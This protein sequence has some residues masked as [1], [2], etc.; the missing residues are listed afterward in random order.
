MLNRAESTNS[1]VRDDIAVV[2]VSRVEAY[3]HVREKQEVDHVAEDR[4][5]VVRANTDAIHRSVETDKTAL[6]SQLNPRLAVGAQVV[7]FR[8]QARGRKKMLGGGNGGNF[9]CSFFWGAISWFVVLFLCLVGL[10]R[11]VK[12]KGFISCLSDCLPSTHDLFG[13]YV[14]FLRLLF[15]ENTL[16]W[17]LAVDQVRRPRQLDQH[18]RGKVLRRD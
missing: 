17:Y 3:Q 8:V 1:P 14:L 10:A 4:P 7:G 15:V 18:G 16:F 13:A 5:T 6:L 12:V 11:R 9:L 2:P